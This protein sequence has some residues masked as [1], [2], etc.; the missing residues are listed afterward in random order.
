MTGISV[1]PSELMAKDQEKIDNMYVTL[2]GVLRAVHTTE[3]SY[4]AIVKNVRSCQRWS[5]PGRPIGL[6]GKIE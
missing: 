6:G 4:T 2:T 5:D 1:I 3:G